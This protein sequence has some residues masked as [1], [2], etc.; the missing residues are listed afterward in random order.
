M[1]E[2]EEDS[3]AFILYKG[4]TMGKR[5]AGMAAF[6]LLFLAGVL[7]GAGLFSGGGDVEVIVITA[8]ENSDIPGTRFAPIPVIDSGQAFPEHQEYSGVACNIKDTYS[9][10]IETGQTDGSRKKEEVSTLYLNNIRFS[11]PKGGTRAF[12]V[13][14]FS[15]YM[16]TAEE[17][18]QKDK[19]HRVEGEDC[20]EFNEGM[21]TARALIRDGYF[22]QP[23][24]DF[25]L[26]YPEL[27]PEKRR[28]E[29]VLTGGGMSERKED[30]TSWWEL[31][32]IL[33][34]RADTGERILVAS[35]D[36][37]R[38]TKAQ[39]YPMYDNA[40]YRIWSAESGYW[41][42]LQDP[43]QDQGRVWISQIPEADFSGEAQIRSYVEA[44]GTDFELLLPSGTD[45]EADWKCHRV[46]G[47]W[48]DYL[49]WSGTTDVYEVTLA[50]PLME[51]G[52]GGWYMASRIRKESEY[53]EIPEHTLSVMMETFHGVPYMHCVKE[54]ET[55]WTLY[56]KYGGA[57]DI[58]VEPFQ[59]FVEVNGGSNPDLIYPG[60][61]VLF[62]Q[63]YH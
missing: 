20:P 13:P 17:Q 48:Y 16:Y 19:W 53:K 31:D 21:E 23:L 29:L 60:Q 61:Y 45:R 57:C 36:I 63:P 41:K 32:Y 39:G 37:I 44:V 47:F 58:P 46:E 12:G 5:K 7:T 54:G 22:Q 50:I 2:N 18:E 27:S 33:V 55:L 11:V 38:V 56:E 49:V 1:P 24:E 9:E 34:T 30:D 15:T 52:A 51:E 25:L 28:Y 10:T 26:Y 4:R 14:V 35:I 42:L 59:S 8:V 40:N 43:S 62:S 6:V 3:P